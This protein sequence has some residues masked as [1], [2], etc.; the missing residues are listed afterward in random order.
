MINK[1]K[2]C[3]VGKINRIL[4]QPTTQ[5][6]YL[7]SVSTG[8][9]LC[10]YVSNV[11]KEG[12]FVYVRHNKGYDKYYRLSFFSESHMMGWFAIPRLDSFMTRDYM[13]KIKESFV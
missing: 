1:D 7:K 11:T 6:W 5:R 12:A 8:E 4:Q 3:S 13:C 10:D 9:T 2:I